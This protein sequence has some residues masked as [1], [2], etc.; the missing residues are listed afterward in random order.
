MITILWPY[1]CPDLHSKRLLHED[2]STRPPPSKVPLLD[3]PNGT[4]ALWY[5][6]FFRVLAAPRGSHPPF[7]P[8]W[9]CYTNVACRNRYVCMS[10]CVASKLF[11]GARFGHG[12]RTRPCS[13]RVLLRVPV[14]DSEK[15]GIILCRV[16]LCSS[17]EPPWFLCCLSSCQR[18][19]RWKG[20]ISI[21]VCVFYSGELQYICKLKY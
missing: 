20:N 12:M 3:T 4:F 10:K 2:H 16:A 13:R 7:P 21:N 9:P 19:H 18:L 15:C 17:F 8:P 5:Y 1:R 14:V 6:F 11:A